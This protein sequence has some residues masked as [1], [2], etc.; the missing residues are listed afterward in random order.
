MVATICNNSSFLAKDDE[1]RKLDIKGR[2]NQP[3]F[4]LLQLLCSGD[5]SE[6]GLIKFVNILRDVEDYR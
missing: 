6:S 5:A 3:D 1:G 4:N 2:I